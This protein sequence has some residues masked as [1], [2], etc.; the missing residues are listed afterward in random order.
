MP[1][2][3]ISGTNRGIGLAL[4]QK[5]LED[6]ENRIVA[7]A[8]NVTGAQTLQ[9]LAE[10][11]PDR[12]LLVPFDLEDPATIEKAAELASAFLPA[13]LDYLV[14]NAGVNNLP[15]DTF[16]E[17]DIGLLEKEIR[18]NAIAPIRVV[19]TL[20]PLVRKGHEKKVVFISSNLASVGNAE[21][22][23]E[24]SNA[25]SMSKAALNM[26]ARKWGTTLKAEGITVL[27]LHP[28]WVGTEMGNAIA[29]YAAKHQPDWSQISIEESIDGCLKAIHD[30]KLEDATSFIDWS[31]KTHP[32]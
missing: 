9:A 14:N 11:H 1:S 22:Y 19:R 8:R 30:A 29:D 24:L 5:L 12:L 17:V 31:G 18:I 15:V 10:K 28:G 26:M 3:F 7:G 2:Y 32:W 21:G 27:L 20:L 13:G 6:P 4:V 16:A 25:Y 23:T